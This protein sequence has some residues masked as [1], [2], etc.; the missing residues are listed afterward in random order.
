M[1]TVQDLIDQYRKAQQYEYHSIL[2]MKAN[3][4]SERYSNIQ[5][6]QI[7]NGTISFT[8]T[9]DVRDVIPDSIPKVYEI[10]VQGTIQEYCKRIQ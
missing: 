1:V 5:N 10:K 9:V 2:V 8:S 7:K 3:G 6:L 4:S